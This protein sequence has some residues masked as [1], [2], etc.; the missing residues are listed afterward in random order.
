MLSTAAVVVVVTSATIV[1]GAVVVVIVAAVAV[2]VARSP[3]RTG[4]NWNSSQGSTR[5]THCFIQGYKSPVH[6]LDEGWKAEKNTR[7][8][9]TLCG[10]T[11]S[12]AECRGPD[13]TEATTFRGNPGK[14]SGPLVDLPAYREGRRGRAH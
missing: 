4:M 7:C 13:K 14:A 6:S 11:A 2:V 12:R 3:G 1:E 5:R 9:R 8:V 10:F